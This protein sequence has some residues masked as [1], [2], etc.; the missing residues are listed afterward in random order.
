MR[1]CKLNRVPLSQTGK[2]ICKGDLAKV[3]D[4]SLSDLP[5]KID[6]TLAISPINQDVLTVNCQISHNE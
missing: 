1:R 3:I 6:G 4:L 5:T 2:R